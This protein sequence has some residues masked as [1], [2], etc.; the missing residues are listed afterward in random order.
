[1]SAIHWLFDATFTIGNQTILWREVIGNLFGLVSA[2]GGM[3]RRV[4]AWPI[5]I[6]GNA[7][8]FTVFLGAVFGTPN[9]VNLFGQAGRQVMFIVVSIY[10]WYAWKHRKDEGLPA[11]APQWA[12]AKARILL[13][14]AL[15]GGTAVLTPIFT[16]LG[17]Y[18]P[19][20]SD[21]WIF[22]GSL[23]ATYGMAKGWVEFWLIWVA[24][25]VVGVPL[26]LSAGYY[27]SA[28]MYVIY[29]IFTLTGFFVWA[30]TRRI[31]AVPVLPDPAPQPTRA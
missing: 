20:W 29:G 17:S 6:A 3:R 9:P 27:A 13:A 12:G 10:G 16:A 2:L 23:L 30:R 1:M 8:L 14:V 7:L 26:L 24:V 18:A 11:V 22:M 28:L 4:W 21:A 5:G 19:V 25:D 31:L 15:V